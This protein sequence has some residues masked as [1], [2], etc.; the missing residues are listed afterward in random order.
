MRGNDRYNYY[1]PSRHLQNMMDFTGCI[2]E[3]IVVHY[4]GNKNNGE[5]LLL[6]Q[7]VLV[8]Q[9]ED[10]RELLLK[11]LV[12]EFTSEEFYSFHFSTGEIALNPMVSFCNRMFE[13]DFYFLAISQDIATHL[14]HQGLHPQIKAGEFF[15]ILLSGIVINGQSTKAIALLKSDNKHSFVKVSG[16]QNG[17]DIEIDK[18]I[19]IDKLEKGCLIFDINAREGFQINIVDKSG[20][21]DLAKFWKESFLNVI[22]QNDNFHATKIVLDIAKKYVTGPMAQQSDVTRVEQADLLNRSLDYFKSNEQYNQEN[23]EQRVFRSEENIESFR[24]FEQEYR[25]QNGY[26]V[27]DDFDI[28]KSAVKQQAR[29]FKS[30][31]KLDKNFHI[32][33]HGDRQLIEQGVDE[34]KGKRF[35]KIYF[36][37]ES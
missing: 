1:L 15:I 5:E 25:E 22:E 14:F 10:L 30:V 36:D 11:Y 16:T 27:I 7:Q 20:K 24:K 31:I 37:E 26:G 32:Y 19:N 17:F 33:I 29:Q 3:Q 18:G 4:V 23:F 35:Y 13:N 21:G 12:T 28:V 34:Q 2:I 6:S 9:H 8:H